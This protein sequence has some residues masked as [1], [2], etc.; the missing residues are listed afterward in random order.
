MAKKQSE[1]RLNRIWKTLSEK[2]VKLIKPECFY[3]ALY[4]AEKSELTFPWVVQG[5]KNMVWK[6]RSYQ[7]DRLPDFL[8]ERKSPWLV[9]K[10]FAEQLERASVVYK[11]DDQQPKSWLSAP[12]V[13]ENRVLGFLVV[14][15][16]VSGA[17]GQRGVRVLATMAR[18][19]ATAIQNARLYER[20]NRRVK[21]LDAVNQIGQKLTARIQLEK[22]EILNLIHEQ[23]SE[24]MDTDNMYIALYEEETDTVRFPLMYVDGKPAHVDARQGGQGRTEWIIRH[25]EPILDRTKEESRAWYQVKGRQEYIGE[26]F[27]SWIG[28]PMIA[29]DD[30]LGVIAVYHKEKNYVYDQHDLLILQSMASQAAIALSN[31]TL[32]DQLKTFQEKVKAREK[33]AALGTVMATLQHRINN[34]FNIIIPNVTRLRSRVDVED[35]T[36]SE[37][38]GIIERNARY[39]SNIISRIQSQLQQE[40]VQRVNIN[41]VIQDVTTKIKQNNKTTSISF[42]FKMDDTIPIITAPSGQIAEVFYN[43]MDNACREMQEGGKIV[44]STELKDDKIYARVKDTGP[45]IPPNIQQ[46]LFKQP[47]SSYEKGGGAGLGLW[48]SQLMLQSINGDICIEKSNQDGTTMCVEIPS[49]PSIIEGG[50]K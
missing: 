7:P 38:L 49:S 23:T 32:V 28:V 42:A 17:F 37:I 8:I 35:D 45:G 24:L 46:R 31:A 19:T 41:T 44:L 25:R 26:P 10:D 43:L 27:A 47:V 9:E 1:Q 13:F 4:D 34:S 29:Q 18:Q 14:E 22:D 15:S 2:V 50:Q 16:Q 33:L 40:Q 20:L 12:M 48:L 5:T 11:P 6:A 3:V 39:T 30:V 21:D 36:I